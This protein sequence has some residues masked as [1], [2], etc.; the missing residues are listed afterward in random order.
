MTRPSRFTDKDRFFKGGSIAFAAAL[1]VADGRKMQQ[2]ANFQEQSQPGLRGRTP[3]V[4]IQGFDKAYR[5][6]YKA[7]M[8][9]LNTIH[10][11]I[12]TCVFARSTSSSPTCWHMRT[13]CSVT[14]PVSS[15]RCSAAHTPHTQQAS[16]D[17][18]RAS[19]VV[20]DKVLEA[21]NKTKTGGHPLACVHVFENDPH[22]HTTRR[23][24]KKTGRGK[25]AICT[26]PTWRKQSH[27][28][29]PAAR[30]PLPQKPS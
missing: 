26:Q 8:R 23:K 7:K 3:R 27:R 20:S 24:K 12:Y 5:S 28:C 4:Y 19:R 15:S 17:E 1:D 9:A 18:M 16:S 29:P 22:Q 25:A 6:I 2:S 11:E 14:S 10:T 21:H 13:M 30:H